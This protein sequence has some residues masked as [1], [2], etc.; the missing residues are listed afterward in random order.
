MRVEESKE[1]LEVG[2]RVAPEAVD[3]VAAFAG[4]YSYGILSYGDA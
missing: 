3:S 2:K 4:V 1:L